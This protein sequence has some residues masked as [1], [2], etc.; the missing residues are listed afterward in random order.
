MKKTKEKRTVLDCTIFGTVMVQVHVEQNRKVV[1]CSQT[2]FVH[3]IQSED[4][5]EYKKL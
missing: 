3:Q 5:R 2:T 1:G 4:Q